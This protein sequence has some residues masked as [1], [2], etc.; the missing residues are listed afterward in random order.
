VSFSAPGVSLPFEADP[1]ATFDRL[2]PGNPTPQPMTNADRVRSSQASVLDLVAGEYD[3]I[4]TRL[5]VEDKRKLEVH[6]DHVRDLELR[7]GQLATVTCERP[8]RPGRFGMQDYEARFDAFSRI[9]ASALGCDL[10]RVVT[11]GMPVLSNAQVS[12]PPGDVHA[13]YAHRDATDAT[14]KQVMTNYHRVHAGHF[15]SL[16]EALKAIP[17]DGGTLLDNTIVLWANEISTGNHKFT[18]M[19]YVLAGKGG[20]TVRPGR[21]VRWAPSIP[22][23]DPN[24]GWQNVDPF[25]GPGHSKLLVSI[26]QSMGVATNQVGQGSIRTAAGVNLDLTGPLGRLT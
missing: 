12:A 1:Q 14:A 23:A 4:K 8:A 11:I 21:Y 5:G 25:N 26:A 15:R 18:K 2:F 20:G 3:Q 19:P 10:T 9:A 13:D 22:T 7:L 16:I 17:E 6:R 24:P